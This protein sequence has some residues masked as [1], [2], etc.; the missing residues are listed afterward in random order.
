[1]RMRDHQSRWEHVHAYAFLLDRSSHFKLNEL[2]IVQQKKHLVLEDDS[3][4]SMP[5]GGLVLI[6]WE[7]FD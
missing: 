5:I 1:M 6:V 2:F 7:V 3:S 4:C